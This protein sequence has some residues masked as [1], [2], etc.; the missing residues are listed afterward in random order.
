MKTDLYIEYHGQQTDY[1][2]LI[3]T[4]KEIWKNGGNKVKDLQSL[5][6]FYKPDER[7]CFYVINGSV[8]GNF[9]A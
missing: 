7:K 8:M 5:E 1:K 4:A 2:Y 6:L 9:D 3:D